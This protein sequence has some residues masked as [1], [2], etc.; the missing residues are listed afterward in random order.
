M[1][2]LSKTVPKVSVKAGTRTVPLKRSRGRTYKS[3]ALTRTTLASVRAVIGKKVTVK[4][5]SATVKVKLTQ[6]ATGGGGGTTGGDEPM[7]QPRFAP[8]GRDLSGTEAANSFGKYFFTSEFSNCAAG[9]WPACA[10]EERYEPVSQGEFEYHRCTPTSGSDIN[11]HSGYEIV[12]AEQKA[13]G[14]WVVEYRDRPDQADDSRGPYHWEVATNGTVKG[15]YQFP[16][17]T[18]EKQFLAD[19]VWRQPAKLGSCTS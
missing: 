16:F 10:V 7:P 14:A 19:F 5:G 3:R 6:S 15:Y 4:A 18:G 9:N 2:T 17:G 13:D 11:F 8:P 12:G 1:V